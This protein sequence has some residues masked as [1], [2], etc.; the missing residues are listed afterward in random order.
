MVKK[1][2][3]I[4][5]LIS[6]CALWRGAAI[7]PDVAAQKPPGASQPGRTSARGT[8]KQINYSKFQHSAH[9]GMVGGVLR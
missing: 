1:V 9:A 5:S 7:L 6:I 2:T 4:L 3:L 8:N